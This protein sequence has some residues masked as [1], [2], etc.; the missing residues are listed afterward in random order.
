MNWILAFPNVYFPLYPYI[1]GIRQ[2]GRHSPWDNWE[3]WISSVQSLS[4]VWLFVTA[5]TAAC[6]ASLSITNSKSLFKLMS[7]E[8]VMPSSH[9]I[10]SSSSPAFNLPSASGSFQMSQFFVS[11]GQRM[12]VSASAISPSSEY[13]GLISFRMD[14]LDLLEVQGTLKSLLQHHSSKTSIL[15]CS[16]FFIV[17]LSHSY[18]TTGKTIS[19]TRWTFVGKVMSLLFNMLSRLTMNMSRGLWQRRQWHP[20]PVLLPGKSHGWRSLVG[21]SPWG[22]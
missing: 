9:L 20:T 10:L 21:C 17:Q 8:L 16:A 13:S 2:G 15:W 5:W 1:I 12:E 3:R 4:R 18:M 6:Q 11:G 22:R 7:T 19:L 14:W